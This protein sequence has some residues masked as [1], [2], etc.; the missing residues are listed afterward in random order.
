MS[1]IA[2]SRP[3]RMQRQTAA[4]AAAAKNS[5]LNPQATDESLAEKRRAL[6]HRMR[7]QVTQ[8]LAQGAFVP[9]GWRPLNILQVCLYLSMVAIDTSVPIVA[10]A[11]LQNESRVLVQAVNRVPKGDLFQGGQRPFSGGRHGLAMA[12]LKFDKEHGAEL[13]N[14]LLKLKHSR[15]AMVGCSVG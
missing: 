5:V 4:D 15:S 8:V 10:E 3:W 2:L 14:L 1:C 11:L 7:S 12:V 6:Q 13:S 9:L